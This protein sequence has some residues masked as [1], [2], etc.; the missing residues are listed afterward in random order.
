MD[1][2]QYSSQPTTG[3]GSLAHTTN[4][5]GGSPKILRVNI[6]NWA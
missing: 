2:E 5:I 1:L 4:R 6:W 3:Q